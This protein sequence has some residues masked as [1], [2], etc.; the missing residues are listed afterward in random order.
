MAIL[1]SKWHS[2][3]QYCRADIFYLEVADSEETGEYL[4]S[5]GRAVLSTDVP[6]PSVDYILQNGEWV[7]PENHTEMIL[8][9][10]KKTKIKKT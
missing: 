8:S 9:A 1:W 5:D 2:S 4:F 6:P 7:L 3:H 10:A